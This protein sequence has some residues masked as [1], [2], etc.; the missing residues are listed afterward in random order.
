LINLLQI[1]RKVKAAYQGKA[2]AAETVAARSSVLRTAGV[3]RYRLG[4]RPIH[5]F[6][7][8]ITEEKPLHRQPRDEPPRGKSAKF[9]ARYLKRCISLN[10]GLSL[11]SAQTSGAEIYNTLPRELVSGFLV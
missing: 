4:T 7:R 1:C 5:A 3:Y 10:G 9:A 11:R 2:V 8:R 6:Y